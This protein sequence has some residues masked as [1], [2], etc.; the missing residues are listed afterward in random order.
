MEASF[1]TNLGMAFWLLAL[2]VVTYLVIRLLPM[3]SPSAHTCPA[4]AADY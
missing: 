1:L 4:P 2:F 3:P